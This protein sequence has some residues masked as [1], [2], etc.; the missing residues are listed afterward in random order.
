MNA[1]TQDSIMIERL[2]TL[3]QQNRA[4]SLLSRSR[5]TCLCSRWIFFPRVFMVRMIDR[6]E[7]PLCR[8]ASRRK[9][10]IA[11]CCSSTGR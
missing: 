6:L 8:S 7:M 3:V 11:T 1:S 10:G 9:T 5:N 4:T 2:E